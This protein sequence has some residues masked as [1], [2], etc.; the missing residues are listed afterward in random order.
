MLGNVLFEQCVRAIDLDQCA[1]VGLMNR[2]FKGYVPLRGRHSTEEAFALPTQPSQVRFSAPLSEWTA[3][4][5][6]TIR[7]NQKKDMSL[8]LS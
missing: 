6:K 3:N 4:M 1:S 7:S 2:H 5:K 8:S